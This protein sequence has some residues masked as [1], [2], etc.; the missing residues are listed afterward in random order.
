[1]THAAP[2]DDLVVKGW[3]VCGE[4]RRGQILEVRGEGGEPPYL[5]RWS[6]TQ[7]V[8]LVHPVPDAYVI[9]HART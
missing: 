3:D 5:V 1:M 7:V 2:G 4:H 8:A 9:H 6:D